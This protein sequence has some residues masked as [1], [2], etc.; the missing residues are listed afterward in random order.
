M[1]DG[2][3]APAMVDAVQASSVFEKAGEYKMATTKG[4]DICKEAN[5]GNI[6]NG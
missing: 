6:Q 3:T 1:V 5:K 2:S 4:S